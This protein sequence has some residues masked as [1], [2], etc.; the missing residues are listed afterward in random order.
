MEYTHEMFAGNFIREVEPRVTTVASTGKSRRYRQVLLECLHCHVH[1]IADAGNAKRTKQKCCS[2]TCYQKSVAVVEGGNEKHPLYPRW[3]A[4]N[5]R[6]NNKTSSNYADYGG[7]GIT[8]SPELQKFPD[9]LDVVS[10]LPNYPEKLTKDIQLDRIDNNRGYAPD[11]L[12]WVDRGVQIANQRKRTNTANKYKGVW[13]SKTHDKWISGV[14][15]NGVRYTSATFK[16]E[17][18]AL[19]HTNAVIKKYGLPHPI[20]EWQE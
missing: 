11:N 1:F 12:R 7:R 3:L 19:E 14:S 18:E 6:C 17:K 2:L 13:Y 16:T 10:K 4:M 20:Q 15:L 9:Y 8:I 5:Q